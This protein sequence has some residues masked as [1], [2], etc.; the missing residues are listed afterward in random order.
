VTALT[1][2]DGPR[3]PDTRALLDVLDREQI[4]ATFFMVGQAIERYP[5]LA[6]EVVRRGHQ[7]GN[8]SYSHSRMLLV[9]PQF[10]R[11]EIARTDALLRQAGATGPLHFRAPFGEKLWSLP[12]VLAEMERLDVLSSV[13][14]RDYARPGVDQI[15]ADVMSQIEPGAVIALHDGGG[16]R[17]Q[18]VAAV[19]RLIPLLRNEGYRFLTV[20]ELRALDGR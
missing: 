12:W 8:H 1:F 16:P 4:R 9:S 15:V 5:E 18:T 7:V 3:E 14:T 10:C 20:D 17:D 11:D 19:Q 6:R 2:D 13:V